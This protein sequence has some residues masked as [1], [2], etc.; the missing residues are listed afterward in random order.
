MNIIS[1]SGDYNPIDLKGLTIYEF[2]SEDQ[3]PAS[4]RPFHLLKEKTADKELW[5]KLLE[6]VNKE[7]GCEK[8][9]E[10]MKSCIIN[11]DLLN[12]IFVG[13]AQAKKIINLLEYTKSLN[14]PLTV[15]NNNKIET[16]NV[17]FHHIFSGN[18][19]IEFNKKLS[20][21]S[22]KSS[23]DET[24][25]I[26]TEFIEK[27]QKFYSGQHVDNPTSLHDYN[28]HV[29]DVL[30]KEMEKNKDKVS[31]NCSFIY[32]VVINL[33]KQDIAKSGTQKEIENAP[34]Q[35]FHSFIL[36][37][38]YS[39]E[40]NSDVTRV[41][42]AY[43][44]HYSVAE[45]YAKMGYGDK[46]EG[47]LTST[48]RKRF[49]ADLRGMLSFGKEKHFEDLQKHQAACFNVEDKLSPP[50]FFRLNDRIFSGLSIRYITS[51]I[52]PRE[53]QAYFDALLNKV[54]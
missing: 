40:K 36:E 54:S 11:F 2:P 18:E 1:K 3:I 43:R 10:L 38:C 6:A 51:K 4:Y 17:L 37:Q 41:H 45:H 31:E 34:I 33:P 26:S 53:C 5:Q 28:H 22:Y 13:E 24:I 50:G 46:D 27:I 21:N 42:H 35:C 49:C 9:N 32:H 15:C 44:D 29:I 14:I 52:D 8:V 25:K 39:P 48:G 7:N 12:M 23:V 16:K 30:E 20:D 47:C 19:V